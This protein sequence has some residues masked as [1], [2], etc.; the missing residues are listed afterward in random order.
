MKSKNIIAGCF[1]GLLITL[2]F[3]SEVIIR[4]YIDNKIQID[5]ITFY[6]TIRVPIYDTIAVLKPIDIYVTADYIY[7][8]KKKPI[9][10]VPYYKGIIINMHYDVDSTFMYN[11]FADC[12]GVNINFKTKSK[13]NKLIK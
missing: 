11:G 8:N 12:D 10:Y 5:T 4:Q 2:P 7:S 13:I 6:D 3:F 9:I 1:I